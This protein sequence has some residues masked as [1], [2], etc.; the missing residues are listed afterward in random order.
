MN[1]KKIIV[2]GKAVLLAVIVTAIVLR[3]Y[4][5]YGGTKVAYPSES[6]VLNSVRYMTDNAT[7]DTNFYNH[8]D[9][10]LIYFCFIFINLFSILSSGNTASGSIKD[11][12][13]QTVTADYFASHW[14]EYLTIGRVVN[15]LFSLVTLVF[16]ILICNKLKNKCGLFVA[17]LCSVFPSYNGWSGLLLSDTCL[18]MLV[19]IATYYTMRYLQENRDSYLTRATVFCALATVQKYPGFLSVFMVVFAVLIQNVSKLK[20]SKKEYLCVVWKNGIKLMGVFTITFMVVAPNLVLHFPKVIK[21]LLFEARSSHLGADGFGYF[22][23]L[24]FYLKVFFNQAGLIALIPL[25]FGAAK[26][27]HQEK[28]N[29]FVAFIGLGFLLIMSKMGLHWERWSL[30]FHISFIILAAYGA[31]WMIVESG[32]QELKHKKAIQICGIVVSVLIVARMGTSSFVDLL[33]RTSPDT[34]LA[35]FNAVQEFGINSSNTYYESYTTLSPSLVASNRKNDNAQTEY[36]MVSSYNYDR[37]FRRPEVYTK[38]ISFYKALD[39]KCELVYKIEPWNGYHLPM[40]TSIYT[41]FTYK[42]TISEIYNNILAV[43]GY[44][45]EVDEKYYGPTI[46]V[47]KVVDNK[48]V[49]MIGDLD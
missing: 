23:N 36:I 42:N 40:D 11:I 37:Y 3:F 28:K 39:E 15:V 49:D 29:A 27:V 38:E 4:G 35:S 26:I 43:A 9:N 13:S 18:T 33:M 34:R 32:K 8:P 31:K 30:V 22:G 19:V 16:L 24:F 5:A 14:S 45:S 6:N 17:C 44:C 12:I 41:D 48:I 2:F 21:V 25:L 46:K 10:I 47:Y 1:R 20:K 7:L